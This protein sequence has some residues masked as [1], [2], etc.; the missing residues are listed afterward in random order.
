MEHVNEYKYLGIYFRSSGIFTQGIKYLCNKALKAIFC[1]KKALISDCMNT[2]LYVTLYN[3]CVKPILL[4]GSEVWSI[5]F[6]INK[7]G[8]TQME[9]RYD[10]FLPEK[11]QLKFLK[12]V[13]GVHKYSVNDAVRADF[14]IFPLAISGL[15][16]SANFWVHLVNSRM[17]SL[18]YLA[19]QDSMNC[20]K[21]FARKFKTFLHNINF[22]HLWNYQNTFSKKR[23][24][25]SVVNKLK[26]SY[27]NFWKDKIHDD[28]KN[29]P[30]GNKLRTYRIFKKCYERETYLFVNELSKSEI[31]TF[32]KLRISSHDLH[33]EKGRHRKTILSE[34]KCFL[35]GMAVEDEKHFVMECDSL[36]THRN[37]FFDNLE[38]I[39]PS[40]SSKNVDEKFS[41]IME[42]KDYDISCVCITNICIMFRAREELVKSISAS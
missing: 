5:D 6:L 17:S 9:N 40:F 19:Y 27:I 8:L 26:N 29:Q 32:A 20:P 15:Q 12:N 30:N 21:G 22:S 34:R 4:Y 7:P 23:F 3:H 36:S 24:L 1:I 16:A 25:H 28:S 35:C 41:F 18:A 10:L 38:E 14:G 13:M 2:G 37:T 31:S 33:I 11:T 42:C 39:V